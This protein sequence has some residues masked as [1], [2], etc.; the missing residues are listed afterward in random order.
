VRGRPGRQ[1]RNPRRD[2]SGG[3]LGRLLHIDSLGR[4]FLDATA[5]EVRTG[6]PVRSE[7]KKPGKPDVLPLPDAIIVAPAS[8]NTINKWA[9]GISDTL[10]LGWITEAIG[11][12]LPIA[13]I[14]AVNGAQAKNPA[15]GRSVE[16]LRAAGVD[17]LHGEGVY[18]AHA[19]GEGAQ[20]LH[21][22]PWHL[23][24]T[25]INARTR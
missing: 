14:P 15:W 2:G 22:I 12:G 9:A 23:S 21:L 8:F 13:T 1:R 10:A 3:R 18:P 19:P 16:T 17:V 7:Y 20:Y 24:L 25:T 11:K 4:N 6:H 5:L